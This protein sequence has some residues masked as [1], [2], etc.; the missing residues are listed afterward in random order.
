M[1]DKLVERFLSYVRIDTQSDR[2]S[3]TLPSTQKQLNLSRQLVAELRQL[4]LSDAAVD[5]YGYVIATLEG[6]LEDNSRVPV[7]GL[8]AHVDTTPDVCGKDVK[9]IIHRNYR[10][11]D[12]P[13]GAGVILKAEDNPLLSMYIGEDIITSDGTTLLGADDKTAVAEI[14]AAV[15]YLQAN[16]QIKHGTI[17]V[18]FTPDEEIGN[19]HEHFDLKKF[20]AKY[21]YTLD[22][23]GEMGEIHDETFNGAKAAYKI[24]GVSAH[25]GYAK[26]KMVNSQ[27]IAAQLVCMF[28]QDESPERTEGDQG[29]Y[30]VIETRGDIEETTVTLT[31]R[32]F[33]KE[34]LER[35]KEQ[36]RAYQ[37]QL[38]GL[39]GEGTVDLIIEDEYS[40]PKEVIDRYPE[41]ADIPCE[42]MR[43][44][45]IEPKRV[46]LRGSTDGLYLTPMGLPTPN[47]SSGG[48]NFHSKTEYTTVINL[49]KCTEILVQ[50]A[51][52]Y[53][54]RY[55]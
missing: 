7:I 21:A 42:A 31:L 30:H 29:F 34:G 38:N 40:S 1:R 19:R 37:R 2:A 15:D 5:G 48:H 14:V 44:V 13:I 23:Y 9:P 16:P 55:G 3:K 36:L 45:G 41:I 52:I 24:K 47:L 26:D 54:E 12:I 27:R 17:K 20:G 18:A 10:R 51:Q 32:D 4:G 35:R 46:K 25:P 53:A 8:I 50:I 28:P 11:G 33:T 39:Y 49:V 43:R 22:W 6:N